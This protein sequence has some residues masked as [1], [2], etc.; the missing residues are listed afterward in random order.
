MSILEH[1]TRLSIAPVATDGR[2]LGRVVED[3]PEEQPSSDD[4]GRRADTLASAHTA[5]QGESARGVVIGE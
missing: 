2:R 4:I 5:H 3:A 1:P